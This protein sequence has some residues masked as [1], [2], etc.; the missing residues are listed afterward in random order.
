MVPA[1]PAD[2]DMARAREVLFRPCSSIKERY[3]N[4]PEGLAL[5]EVIKRDFLVPWDRRTLKQPSHRHRQRTS[6]LP[7]SV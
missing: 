3:P 7:S 2:I 1:F 5:L 4:V 6:S